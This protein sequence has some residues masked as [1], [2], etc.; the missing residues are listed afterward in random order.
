VRNLDGILL[1][2]IN[3]LKSQM[4]DIVKQQKLLTLPTTISTPPTITLGNV[5]SA[6]TLTN[7]VI[8]NAYIT[9]KINPVF[10]FTGG[11]Y[12]QASAYYPKDTFVRNVSKTSA[13]D[14]G[15]TYVE[16]F[17]YG[18]S[19]EIIESGCSKYRM[20]IDEGNGY[21]YVNKIPQDGSISD[22]NIYLRK[23][24]FGIANLRKIKLEIYNGG[25]GGIITNG[26]DSLGTPSRHVKNAIFLGDSYTEAYSCYGE[27][28]SKLLGW[29]FWN[30]GVGGTGYLNPNSEAGQVKFRDRI[31][32]DVIRY[33]PDYL[34]IA[35]GIND[36]TFSIEDIRAEASL[37]YDTIK[38]GSSNTKI[39]VLSGWFPRTPDETS[40]AI[41]DV[42]KVES[43]KRGMAFVDVLRGT[44]YA[45]DG[46]MLTNMVGSWITGIGNA[47]SIQTTGNASIFIS[48]DNTHPVEEGHKYLGTKLAF[49]ILKILNN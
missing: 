8:Y 7:P 33:K 27:Y 36:R 17:H 14:N 43:Q 12:I 42:L 2:K 40:L 9:D 16:F 45:Y 22:G 29:D 34:V 38:I 10:L 47:S 49:E 13:S 44:T 48:S 24:S 15:N 26:N 39:I 30:S 46:T 32:H 31:Q 35:G 18:E 20:L 23:V 11:E 21:Q 19:F 37:L 1:S 4:T 6:S 25:F 5:N 3:K 28:A 41:A